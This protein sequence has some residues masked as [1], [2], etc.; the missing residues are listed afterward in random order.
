MAANAAAGRWEVSDKTGTYF[1]VHWEDGD[2]NYEGVRGHV[3]IDV[4]AAVMKQQGMDAPE[5]ANALEHVYFRYVPARRGSLD[6]LYMECSRGPGAFPVT[7]WRF[8]APRGGAA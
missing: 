3:G 7:V 8:L 1:D 4:F 6:G 5:D 2:P